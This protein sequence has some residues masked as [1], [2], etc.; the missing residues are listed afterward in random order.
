M[1]GHSDS[2]SGG[3][4]CHTYGHCGW[5]GSKAPKMLGQQEEGWPWEGLS[6]CAKNG[7]LLPG[8]HTL[9]ISSANLRLLR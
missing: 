9:C 2:A 8:P 5:L 7:L 1:E 3:Y 4:D 6:H